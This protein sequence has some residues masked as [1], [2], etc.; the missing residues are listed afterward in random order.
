MVD[1][2]PVFYLYLS[3]GGYV[4]IPDSIS[5]FEGTLNYNSSVGSPSILRDPIYALVYPFSISTSYEYLN[6][7][8]YLSR[9]SYLSPLS[10]SL[11]SKLGKQFLQIDGMFW[12]S[13]IDRVGDYQVYFARASLYAQKFSFSTIYTLFQRSSYIG[14]YPY[15]D[16]VLDFYESWIY[17]GNYA[18]E[19]SYYGDFFNYFSG[20]GMNEKGA[21]IWA[22]F[23]T[24]FGGYNFKVRQISY[25][26]TTLIP[27]RV[28]GDIGR[29]WI[30]G[31]YNLA[32]NLFLAYVFSAKDLKRGLILEN[33][34]EHRRFSERGETSFSLRWFI[35]KGGKFYG[36]EPMVSYTFSGKVKPEIF[37]GYAYPGKMGIF[38]GMNLKLFRKKFTVAYWNTNRSFYA[39]LEVGYARFGP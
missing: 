31:K 15:G 34:I 30:K 28:E 6:D 29:V 37:V 22:G 33:R 16:Q 20:F 11:G 23:F 39:G 2:L 3:G 9:V 17:F 8:V 24:N 21:P 18:F 32:F 14:S 38:L 25:L 27:V 10:F 13:Y 26:G 5:N 1:T 19:I 4:S 35:S 7:S 12:G 36:F